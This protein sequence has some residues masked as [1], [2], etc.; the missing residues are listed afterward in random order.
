MPCETDRG[1]RNFRVLSSF[2]NGL[3]GFWMSLPREFLDVSFKIDLSFIVVI[4][5]SKY[6]G[7]HV[8]QSGRHGTQ[9]KRPDSVHYPQSGATFT[10]RERRNSPALIVR[11]VFISPKI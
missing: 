1:A 7:A 9:C 6:K 2:R 5:I 4:T 10:R 11:G 8:V 3:R